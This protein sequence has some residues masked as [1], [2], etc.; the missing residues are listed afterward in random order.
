M[1]KRKKPTI[2]QG[3]LDLRILRSLKRGPMHGYAITRHQANNEFGDRRLYSRQCQRVH[4]GMRTWLQRLAV[5][6]LVFSMATIGWLGWTLLEMQSVNSDLSNRLS[7]ALASLGL[8]T[9]PVNDTDI[10]GRVTDMDGNPLPHVEVLLIH[11]S[12][13]NNRF[14]HRAYSTVTNANGEYKFEDQYT[15][16][17]QN[18][19]LVTILADDYAM[20][21]QYELI[22]PGNE[23]G[24]YDFRLESVQ[25]TSFQFVD[26]D[27]KPL[28]NTNI[29]LS[30]RKTSDAVDH[31]IYPISFPKATWKTDENGV[32]NLSFFKTDDEIEF[33]ANPADT[34]TSIKVLIS[35]ES[36]EMEPL[37]I[38]VPRPDRRNFKG[39][40]KDEDGNPV[41][42]A[43]VLLLHKSWPNGRY[44]QRG[45][46]TTTND[47]GEYNFAGQYNSGTQ[48]AFLITIFVEKQQMVSRYEVFREGEDVT[49]F[50]FDLEP[51]SSTRF[52]FVDDSG[53][54]L[55]NADIFV[56]NR[57][58]GGEDY[59]VYPNSRD[60]AT[61]Q[62]D[63]EGVVSLP[64][65]EPGDEVEFG[66]I[67]DESNSK[68]TVK[69]EETD[70]GESQ[71]ITVDEA[72][73]ATAAATPRRPEPD[74]VNNDAS[75]VQWIKDNAVSFRTVDPNDDDFADLEK[76][77]E[78]IGDARIVQLG[79]Q[80]H[81]D[82]VCFE[83]KIRLIRFLHQEMGFDVL[84][85]ESGLYDCHKAWQAFKAGKDPL[86]AASQGVFGIWTGS[87]QT[88]EMWNYL[89]KQASTD[90][91]L[92]LAGF[93]C[94][95]T[96]SASQKL[97]DEIA[98]LGDKL[99]GASLTDKE[100]EAFDQSLR[101][102]I[103]NETP[104]QSKEDFLASLGKLQSAVDDTAHVDKSEISPDVAAFWQQQFKSMAD[105]CGRQFDKGDVMDGVMAR[106]EQ[107]ARNL[108]W[109]ANERFRD[110]KIIVWAASFHIMR[111]PPGITSITGSADYSDMIQMGHRVHEAFGDE[112]YTIGFTAFDGKAG[113]F[114]RSP[115]EIGEAPEGTLESLCQAA[116]Y[117]TK[118]SSADSILLT[119]II[120]SIVAK[121]SS[122][123]SE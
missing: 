98:E 82:G 113:A 71:T 103:T 69:I 93:D 112:V 25:P 6:G 53:N 37:V 26:P 104:G 79:E 2:W 58:S 61:W 83:T 117:T 4:T 56:S 80:S 36:T 14:M 73:A 22:K 17:L 48:N 81:G 94:Q 86:E 11:K 41:A 29:F 54:A 8:V 92:E 106:D 62:T 52:R 33:V 95:F 84:A 85:F 123:T 90:N 99:N 97:R 30:H 55:A 19:F 122:S 68:L 118:R 88:A 78:M 13:P 51:A 45:Y 120:A 7:S 96:A 46:A 108:I 110:R 12:W 102:L 59:M 32:L 35:E 67:A 23:A 109:L 114:F 121:K 70:D 10:K 49:D 57:N 50:D 39:M 18:A 21:S 60:N 27:G 40:V 34:R 115:F 119:G 38:S 91:P 89:A 64:Y 77:K 3:S 74:A 111:N 116:E 63:D 42:G 66:V 76:L 44:M 87:A 15:S 1:A 9:P 105:H 20:T 28:S 24:D 75:H 47:K 31:L 107:M 65:F 16:K 100:W 101:R 5:A 43:R 72:K